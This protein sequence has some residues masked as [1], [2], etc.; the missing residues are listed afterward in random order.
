MKKILVLCT[1][2]ACRS[3][4]AEGYLRFFTQNRTEV[5]SAGLKP[6]EVHPLAIE[7]MN[8]DNI[9]ISEARSKSVDDFSGESYDF[10][11]TVCRKAELQKPADISASVHLHFD[12]ADPEEV[13]KLQDPKEA[14]ADARERVKREMLRFIGTH[15]DLYQQ[16]VTLSQ[17]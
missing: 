15:D 17:H 6:T 14:F 16:E 3:Q 9:D 5:V 7:V 8:E 4:M 12:I 1:G 13:A 11:I 2:N 10:L